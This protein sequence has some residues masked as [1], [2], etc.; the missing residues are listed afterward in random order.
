MLTKHIVYIYFL[1]DSLR[2]SYKPM[3][4][5]EKFVL[6]SCSIKVLNINKKKA[7]TSPA[8][9]KFWHEKIWTAL[10]EI[11]NLKKIIY[12]FSDEKFLG[13]NFVRKTRKK[14]TSIFRTI[15]ARLNCVSLCRCSINSTWGWGRFFSF[16]L[17]HFLLRFLKE[18]A[19]S[20]ADRQC[21][22]VK[23]RIFFPWTQKLHKSFV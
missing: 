20:V 21:S 7:N 19:Y 12:K 15:S 14:K 10:S 17:M 5:I 16:I 23:S 8:D 6:F 4:K 18:K 1:N 13:P 9:Y 2:L 22:R 11:R 3:A